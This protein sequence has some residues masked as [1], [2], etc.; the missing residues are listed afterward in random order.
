[1][2][3]ITWKLQVPATAGDNRV[4]MSTETRKDQDT[5]RWGGI[6]FAIGFYPNCLSGTLK[7][8]I[9]RVLEDTQ[10]EAIPQHPCQDVDGLQTQLCYLSSVNHGEQTVD[11]KVELKGKVPTEP[12]TVEKDNPSPGGYQ[13]LLFFPVD[14]LL[15]LSVF[16]GVSY[17]LPLL[18]KKHTF[19]INV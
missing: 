12:L 17:T 5:F 10:D 4:N 1:M 18:L 19:K 15:W 6:V 9:D 16:V 3:P 2:W 13:H 7:L 8:T 11:P 14:F